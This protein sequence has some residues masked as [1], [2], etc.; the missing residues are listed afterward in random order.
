MRTQP[1]E[2]LAIK[3]EP[4]KK[5]ETRPNEAQRSVT[6][7]DK[8]ENSH[9]GSCASDMNSH[10]DINSKKPTK[11]SLVGGS[12]E[13]AHLMRRRSTIGAITPPTIE[14]TRLHRRDSIGAQPPSLR[15]L[16]IDPKVTRSRRS[17][18]APEYVPPLDRPST[19]SSE[20]CDI[21]ILCK[22]LAST[23]DES[24]GCS[25]DL[26]P[27]YI[28]GILTS[29]TN[30]DATPRPRIK[31]VE[32]VNRPRPRSISVSPSVDRSFENPVENDDT[33]SFDEAGFL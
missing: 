5:E 4:A 19:P 8:S 9:T 26:V 28:N 29:G 10:S 16:S 23:S 7:S 6:F 27:Y 21:E 12:A 1:C 18:T 25:L 15:R 13:P 20:H 17:S 11:I 33:P 22:H 24:P 30:E 3:A 14:P 2:V 32:K 31:Q